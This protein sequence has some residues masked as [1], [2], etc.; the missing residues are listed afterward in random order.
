MKV[1]LFSKVFA[2]TAATD[3]QLWLVVNYLLLIVVAQCMLF[4]MSKSTFSD[5]RQLIFTVL[6]FK[7]TSN[8]FYQGIFAQCC[9]TTIV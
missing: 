4:Q 1:A 6:G 9:K 8:V 5:L 7:A 3:C 2:L